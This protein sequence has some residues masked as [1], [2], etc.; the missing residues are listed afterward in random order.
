MPSSH[1][2]RRDMILGIVGHLIVGLLDVVR[3]LLAP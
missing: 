3:V 2:F 1:E